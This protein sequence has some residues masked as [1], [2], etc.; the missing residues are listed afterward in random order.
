MHV[1]T[2]FEK[3]GG[4]KEQKLQ[5]FSDTIQDCKIRNPVSSVDISFSKF[6]NC[7]LKLGYGS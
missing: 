5:Q 7:I 1:V 6:D 4:L 3:I 2:S